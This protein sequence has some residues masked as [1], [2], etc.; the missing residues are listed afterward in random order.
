MKTVSLLMIGCIS[1]MMCMACSSKV[2]KVESQ[3]DSIATVEAAPQV[4][5]VTVQ[6]LAGYFLKNTYKLSDN[7]TCVLFPDQASLDK[8]L[9]VAKTMNNKVD[10]P[11]FN[12][13]VV[14]AIAMQPTQKKTEITVGKAE[15]IG[16]VV[17][18]YVE[19]AVGDNL[20]YTMKPL[21]VISFP[22]EA[23]VN[24]VNFLMDGK[25]IQSFPLNAAAAN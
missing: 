14:A 13:S 17:N 3:S 10:K 12:Q 24:T 2:S 8:A 6:T 15:K 19:A 22:K 7:P 20:T 11:D 4:L 21:L 18:L 25:V 1:M 16:Q 9:G 23:D 5:P